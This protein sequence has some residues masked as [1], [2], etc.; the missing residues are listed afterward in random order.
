MTSHAYLD[1]RHLDPNW[2]G[3][4]CPVRACISKLDSA[5]SR[6]GE[7]P[8]CLEHG[9]RLHPNS[10]T[11]VYYHGP[12]RRDRRGAAMRNI[13]FHRE[14]FEENVLG[15]TFKAES[16]RISHETS[17]DAL[18]WN[19][20]TAIAQAGL[21]TDL[22]SHIVRGQLSGESELYLWGLRIPCGAQAARCVAFPPLLA[23][24]E[25]F[26]FDIPHFNTEPDIMI[27]LP[28][29]ILLAIEAK[30][31]S[32]NPLA[33]ARENDLA[34]EKPQ[35]R[36][37]ITRRYTPKALN[38]VAVEP[39]AVESSAPF[40]SQLYRNLIFVIHMAEQLGVDWHLANL[41]SQTQFARR[42]GDE[43]CDP[44]A[45]IQMVVPKPHFTFLRWEEVYEFASAASLSVL[46]DYM[47]HKTA[48]LKVAFD[49][50]QVG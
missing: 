34:G 15:N 38:S 39:D 47:V 28:N 46:T 45:F 22:A 44:T 23:A 11:F 16:G 10:S 49:L 12:D 19:V 3:S 41:V 50:E 37:G 42:R 13:R 30:F 48:H 5:P 8:Y 6:W 43:Y 2:D 4:G 24:R 32:G 29:R 14:L 20:F 21:L 26:E 33:L 25:T 40:Y 17:E 27:L 18:T 35:S 31:T 7:M 36:E 1:S 9:I